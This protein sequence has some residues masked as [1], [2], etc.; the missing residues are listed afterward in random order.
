MLPSIREYATLVRQATLAGAHAVELNFG[1][2]NMQD[3]GAFAPI[4]SYRPTMVA[5]ALEHIDPDIDVELWVK[6]S[7]VFDDDLFYNLVG[8]LRASIM[9]LSPIAGVVA[10]NTLP[11]C[12]ALNDGGEPTLSFGTGVGGMAGMA[13]KPIALAQARRWVREGFRVIGAGGIASGRD[14][15]DFAV[16]GVESCQANTVVQ[17]EG[18]SALNRIVREYWA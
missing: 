1:C 6:V 10:I 2:P 8:V 16:V 13:L 5:E 18:A 12:L 4:I 3:G 9:R 7:P 11:Q 17:T 14:L 15:R